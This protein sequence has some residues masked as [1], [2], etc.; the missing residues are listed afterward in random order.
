M[1]KIIGTDG[2][3]Y[4]PVSVDQL[5]RWIAEG[6]A[7]SATLVQ[8]EGSTDWK[9]LSS[10]PEFAQTTPPPLGQYSSPPVLSYDERKSKIAAGLLGIFLGGMGVHRFYLGY[11]TI[12]VIQ[13]LV[14]LITCGVGHFW[15]FIEG[16][17]II[18]GTTITTDADGR[19]LK[20]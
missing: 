17:L 1:Y 14:T 2:K 11:T 13:I 19:P 18:A 4:G 12:G 6:R 8:T 10:F 5:R 16:V 7:N 20:D 3:Q 15:G 9:P